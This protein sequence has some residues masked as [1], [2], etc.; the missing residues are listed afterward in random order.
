MCGGGE[1]IKIITPPP[2]AAA[3][4]QAHS[5]VV[6]NLNISLNLSR[7]SGPLSLS[8]IIS[9]SKL[10]VV[11]LPLLVPAAVV[12]VARMLSSRSRRHRTQP[13][14]QGR[15]L[16]GVVGGRAGGR[17]R[18]RGHRCRV[19]K[20][21]GAA[22]R[23]AATAGTDHVEKKCVLDT[24]TKDVDGFFWGSSIAISLACI[25]QPR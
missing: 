11:S 1:E 9:G 17:A 12:T 5:R 18:R 15:G 19:P 6:D 24:P 7:W 22:P 4:S 25:N 3:L 20:A 23:A 8:L 16:H 14:T 2:A 10:V 21:D 13:T